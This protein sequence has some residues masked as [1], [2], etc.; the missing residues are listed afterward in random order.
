M[1]W[2]AVRARARRIEAFSPRSIRSSGTGQGRLGRHA[3]ITDI[4]G[5]EPPVEEVSL[6]PTAYRERLRVL[7]YRVMLD[8]PVQLAF[9]WRSLPRRIPRN[10]CSLAWIEEKQ[11]RRPGRRGW[12]GGPEYWMVNSFSR[13]VAG[14]ELVFQPHPLDPQRP[15]LLAI[16]VDRVPQ[17][18]LRGACTHRAMAR[19]AEMACRDELTPPTITTSAVR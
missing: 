18:L 9:S 4:A 6:K 10:E 19:S 13:A 2:A 8:I 14:K 17:P 16:A 15:A 11:L 12:A 3:D 5:A 7:S 1:A